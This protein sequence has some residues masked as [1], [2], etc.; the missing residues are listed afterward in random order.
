MGLRLPAPGLRRPLAAAAWLIPL[1]GCA[2]NPVT[3]RRELSFVS[4]SKEIALGRE[5]A[6]ETTRA[7]PPVADS[8]LQAYV[9]RIGLRMADESERPQLPW[10]FIV[11]EDA[12]VNAFAFP[13]GFIFVTR[14]IVTHM[15]SEA[16]L[17][18]VVG[19]EI[20]HVTARHTAT[21]ITR[22][23]LAQ[24]GMVAGSLASPAVAQLFG[25]ASNSLGL[26]FLKFSRDAENQA[27]QLGFRY[28]MQDGYDPRAMSSMFVMLQR[29]STQSAVGRLP[30][31]QSTHPFPENRVA[32]NETRLAQLPQGPEG[33]ALNRDAFARA[34]DGLAFAEDPRQ[35]F[36]EDE[37][38]NHPDLKFRLRFPG[39]WK[40]RNEATAV[41]AISPSQNAIVGLTFAEPRTPTE[42]L[43]A[44]YD[45][46]GVTAG[47]RGTERVHGFPA[48]VGE[49]RADGGQETIRG[50]VAFVQDGATLY[51]IIGYTGAGS[52]G[53]YEE[54]F[55]EAINSFD[56]LTDP[57]ALAKQPVRVHM[58]RVPRDMSFEEFTRT[59]PSSI[60]LEYLAAINGR[61]LD[62]A[63]K[64]GDWAKQVR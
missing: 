60:P 5:G 45:Q 11:L 1:V 31:W 61:G 49:F 41:S 12:A 44:F 3:G 43:L 33:L 56:R 20:G 39:G 46:R 57:A 63:F 37:T 6:A 14:G 53:E 13:G 16:E 51:Q 29:T 15:T 10:S 4:E 36:F 9:R 48:A 62:G 40:T 19:H 24:I 21:M 34:I 52:Y 25:M 50:L 64:R 7:I 58:I 55:R 32:R 28:M 23:Q 59:Y 22:A 42:A 27:D 17:A 2:V 38:F 26:L 35:G 54:A 18:S 30:E 47:R 8:G